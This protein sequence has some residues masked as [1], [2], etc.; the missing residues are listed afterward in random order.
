MYAGPLVSLQQVLDSREQRVGR[1]R[2]WLAAH[3]LPLISFTIN[4]PGEV[5]LNLISRIAFEQGYAEIKNVC[6]EQGASVIDSGVFRSDCGHE[7]LIVVAGIR[8]EELK[9]RMVAIEDNHPLGR[10]FDIDVLNNQ[11]IAL[12]R[13]QF[14]HPRRNCLLCGNDAKACA[15]NRIHSLP[16]LI[17]KM[18]EMINDCN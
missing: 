11:G 10:L 17:D 7:C 2:E 8:V 1:Q 6:S 16:A 12:S 13:S 4:M 3:S 18:C 9:R 5:K 15:R 14:G